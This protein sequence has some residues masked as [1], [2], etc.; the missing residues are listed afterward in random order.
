MAAGRIQ[1]RGLGGDLAGVPDIGDPEEADRAAGE[2]LEPA[3]VAGED[4]VEI[5]RVGVD[6]VRTMT[7]V[8]PGGIRRENPGVA[9]E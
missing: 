5:V 6:L 1:G 7:A 3:L 2:Y 4:V 8:L 9:K